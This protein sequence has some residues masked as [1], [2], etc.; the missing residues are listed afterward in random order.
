[1]VRLRNRNKQRKNKWVQDI[2]STIAGKITCGNA[3]DTK[4]MHW[5]ATFGYEFRKEPKETSATIERYVNQ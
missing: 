5:Q 1:M 4:F 3:D 2:I